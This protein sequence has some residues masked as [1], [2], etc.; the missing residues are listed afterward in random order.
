[1]SK[2]HPD[3]H[4]HGWLTVEH[5]EAKGVEVTKHVVDG[6]AAGKTPEQIANDVVD[7]VDAAIPLSALGPVGMAIDAID[8]P[9]IKAVIHLVIVVF[10]KKKRAAL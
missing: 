9:I 2:P 5:L 1:M 8:G 10:A 3:H 4:A 6:L 7:V